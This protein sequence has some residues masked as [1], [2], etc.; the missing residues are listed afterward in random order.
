MR[1]DISRNLGCTINKRYLIP[2]LN[3]FSFETSVIPEQKGKS[4]SQLSHQ[5]ERDTNKDGHL[6]RTEFERMVKMQEPCATEEQLSEMFQRLDRDG[7]GTITLEEMYVVMNS[8]QDEGKEDGDRDGKD[9]NENWDRER[10]LRTPSMITSARTSDGIEVIIDDDW[11]L[12]DEEKTLKNTVRDLVGEKMEISESQ[13]WEIM[14]DKLD[15][16]DKEAVFEIFKNLDSDSSGSVSFDELLEV[17]REMESEDTDASARNAL[18]LEDHLS[19]DRRSISDHRTNISL[20][21]HD[22]DE[23]EKEIPMLEKIR[24]KYI[25]EIRKADRQISILSR[26]C[27]EHEA[28]VKK[29]LTER[30]NFEAKAQMLES[31]LGGMREESTNRDSMLLK[32]KETYESEYDELLKKYHEQGEIIER[33]RK[34]TQVS[35]S[36]LQAEVKSLKKQLA[37]CEKSSTQSDNK[38]VRMSQRIKQLLQERNKARDESERLRER[39]ETIIR[40]HS[41]LTFW[42]SQHDARDG[43]DDMSRSSSLSNPTTTEGG[44][45]ISMSTSLLDDITSTQQSNATENKVNSLISSN[46]DAGQDSAEGKEEGSNDSPVPG[47]TD[48]KMNKNKNKN[49]GR[50]IIENATL[51]ALT[52]DKLDDVRKAALSKSSL[53]ILPEGAVTAAIDAERKKIKN[54]IRRLQKRLARVEKERGLIRKEYDIIEEMGLKVI[55]IQRLLGTEREGAMRNQLHDVVK[56]R[57]IST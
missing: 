8:I 23:E 2:K 26:K 18:L 41:D 54:K 43:K 40:E 25:D 29:I 33:E 9:G 7:D 38:I 21:T 57:F 45:L 19:E 1:K 6:D 46:A 16:M 11:T 42:R 47:A 5:T 10:I 48:K 49:K 13:F 20:N 30:A 24:L 51:V 34:E 37:S 3:N 44:G 31:K 15:G 27:E 55:L 56:M 50:G 35:V 52:S 32:F 53:P 39:E 36:E 4:N 12:S 14:K 17:F 22:D 28:T